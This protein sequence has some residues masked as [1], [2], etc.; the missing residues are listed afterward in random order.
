ML[1]GTVYPELTMSIPVICSRA[2]IMSV[3][4]V[5]KIVSFEEIKGQRSMVYEESL[6]NIQFFFP[7][8]KMEIFLLWT[9]ASV[10]LS[11]LLKIIK[12]LEKNIH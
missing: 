4:V 1:L 9:K 6:K 7:P 5:W 2:F 3:I 8:T 12:T 11:L 10:T